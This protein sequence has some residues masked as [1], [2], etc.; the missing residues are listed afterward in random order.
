MDML[1]FM[2]EFWG[3]MGILGLV[4]VGGIRGGHVLYAR[5]MAKKGMAEIEYW[6]NGSD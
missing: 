1:A 6:A 5:G 2:V 3:S 4:I